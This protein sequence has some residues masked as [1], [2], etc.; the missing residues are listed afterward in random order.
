ML[1]WVSFRV[2][3]TL[4]VVSASPALAWNEPDSFRGVPW[5]TS[6][7][8]TKAALQKARDAILQGPQTLRRRG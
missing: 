8:E 2:A 6:Q 5:G 1:E 4:L 3:V 7:E